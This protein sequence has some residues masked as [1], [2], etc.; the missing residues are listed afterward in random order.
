[1]FSIICS[2]K[3]GERL[4][5]STVQS[6]TAQTF[7]D[8]ELI[9]I[10]DGSSDGTYSELM[11]YSQL[12]DRITVIKNPKNIGLTRA[13][14]L[15]IR[16]SRRDW[17]GRIDCGDRWAG[18]KLSLQVDAIRENK[19]LVL[20]GTQSTTVSNGSPVATRETPLND[21]EIR[22]AIG[23]GINPFV[24]S[25]TVFKKVT[26]Y[27]EFFTS[28]QDFELWTRLLCFGQG[29]IL[30]EP[31]V[32]YDLDP[33]SI[34]FRKQ[35]VSFIYQ[36]MIVKQFQELSRET[37][38]RVVHPQDQRA[39][40]IK[41]HPWQSKLFSTI[42]S[43]GNRIGFFSTKHFLKLLGKGIRCVSF[44]VVPQLWFTRL[45]QYLRRFVFVNK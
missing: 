7:S 30:E 45:R 28:C 10:D 15:G 23:R 32:F 21:H 19:N 24:H 36:E 37:G 34:T 22:R 11:R 1:M 12:D 2:V 18:N 6:V 43:F 9:L 38:S 39:L 29:K 13:L 17:I 16:E 3:N 27:D 44:L 8:W 25:S 26:E 4:V 31:L 35:P 20:L 14:N 40:S 41:F 5:S 33:N 42:Y